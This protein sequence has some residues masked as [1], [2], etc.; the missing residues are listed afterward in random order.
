ML[1][2]NVSG[3]V[4]CQHIGRIISPRDLGERKVSASKADL[5]SKGRTHA[6][7]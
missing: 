1:K 4:L 5:E 2:H 3:D 6:S 7:L